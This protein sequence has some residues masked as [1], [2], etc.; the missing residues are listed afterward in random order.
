MTNGQKIPFDLVVA[1]EVFRCVEQWDYL[2][3]SA[4][5][6]FQKVHRRKGGIER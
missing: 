5:C 1:D 6:S 4:R 3:E 2:R